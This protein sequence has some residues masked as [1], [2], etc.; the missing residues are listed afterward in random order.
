[1]GLENVFG[2]PAKI[3][4]EKKLEVI[5]TEESVID[6]L[7]IHF[8]TSTT[9]RPMSLN[10]QNA[11]KVE[12]QK[13][14][15]KYHKITPNL[16]ST[17]NRTIN[18]KKLGLEIFDAT[19]GAF[20][21]ALIQTSYNQGFNNFEFGEIN[22]NWF[23]IYLQGKKGSLIKIKVNKING[24]ATLFAAEYCFLKVEALN[25]KY[26]LGNTENC[27]AEISTK[28]KGSLGHIRNCT[29]YSPNQEVLDKL[30]KQQ[31]EQMTSEVYEWVETNKPNQFCL[32]KFKK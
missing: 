27:L 28:E 9:K 5:A 31:K 19:S 20:L 14:L 30:K 16:I 3:E 26:A 21:S 23:G 22:I 15:Q 8:K 29:I 11:H 13:F 4:P 7:L 6:E 12:I 2:K 18:T 1:M 17:F 32:G 24:E 10:D 25:G